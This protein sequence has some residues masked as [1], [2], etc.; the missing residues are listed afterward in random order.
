MPATLW[1]SINDPETNYTHHIGHPFP[2]NDPDRTHYAQTR[3]VQRNTGN[4]YGRVT[5]QDQEEI[6]DEVDICGYHG[7][8]NFFQ[9]KKEIPAPT[10]D[11]LEKETTSWQEGYD[12]AMERMLNRPMTD[13]EKEKI[14][15]S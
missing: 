12:A 10:L 8:A 13:P 9:T 4:S 6:T 2:A 11:E 3:V 15:G 14:H 5:Y 7:K 1:C